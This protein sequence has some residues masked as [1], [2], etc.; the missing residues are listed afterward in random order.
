MSDPEQREEPPPPAIPPQS[1]R[2]LS[3]NSFQRVIDQRIA[4]AE[5]AGF[6]DNLPGA[7]KPLQLDDDALTPEEDRAAY[8]LLKNAGYSLPWIEL[9]KTIEA[10][11][12]KLAAWIDRANRG[13]ANTGPNQQQRLRDEYRQRLTEINRLI[14][15]YNLSAPPV[16]GQL[17][18]LQPWREL[19]KLGPE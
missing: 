18:L 16:V 5:S 10:E 15:N 19:R 11:Q 2:S 8:R 13:W 7:G 14:T 4:D 17:P 9:R 3:I 1:R 6:F 12:S